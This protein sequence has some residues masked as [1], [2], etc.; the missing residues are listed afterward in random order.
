MATI[1]ILSGVLNVDRLVAV[2]RPPTV[3]NQVDWHYI[4]MLSYDAADAWIEHLSDLDE[5]TLGE[6]GRNPLNDRTA[7]EEKVKQYQAKKHFIDNIRYYSARRENVP[8]YGEH[9]IPME[10]MYNMPKFC[11]KEQIDKG[12][13]SLNISRDYHLR[14]ICENFPNWI[15]FQRQFDTMAQVLRD[16]QQ[17][18]Q[19][20]QQTTPR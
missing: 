7:C 4:N 13:L 10:A 3:N 9:A 5:N 6:C 19:N 18:Q 1:V 20:L 14:K 17:Q 8:A 2:W 16:T 11:E 15:A 12:F